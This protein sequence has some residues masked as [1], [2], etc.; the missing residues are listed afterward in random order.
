MGSHEVVHHAHL[1]GS[2]EEYVRAVAG[3]VEAGASRGEPAMVAVPGTKGSLLQPVLAGLER[4]ELVDLC[5][6][7]R[8]PGRF[9]P[10]AL[11]FA[12]DQAEP[13][14]I[15][16]EPVWPGRERDE[17]AEAVRHEAM[18]GEAR[19]ERPVQMLCLYDARRLPH[20]TITEVWRTHPDVTALGVNVASAGY[21]RQA[22]SIPD[23]QW[24]LEPLPPPEETIEID[25]ERVTPVR[26]GAR[27]LA[28]SVGLSAERAEDL[29]LA[30]TELAWRSII[31]GGGHGRA[32]MWEKSAGAAVCEISDQAG[33]PE[34]A[35]LWLVN[36]LCD[37][38]QVRCGPEGTRI[39]VRVG[40]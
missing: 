5:D 22:G 40:P 24:P 10:A 31:S 17:V 6:L 26:L 30:A 8:N 27:A 4:I 35:E 36:Q 1:Y 32:R 25:F 28:A 15:V 23:S 16:A 7:G 12:A 37:L 29:V 11:D 34:A 20:E 2:P 9:L 33:R 38:V 19:A 13:V 39:R 18:V 14:R 21:R 3:F